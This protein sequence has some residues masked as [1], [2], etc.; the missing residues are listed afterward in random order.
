MR[1]ALVNPN[2]KFDGSIYFGCREAHLPLEF[3][4][5]RALLEAEGHQVELIDAQLHNLSMDEVV[6][7]VKAFK[8]DFAVVTSA[9]SYLFWRCAPPE[10]T[11]PQQ[12]IE[13]VE[14]YAGKTVLVGPHA[15]TT[16]RT[17]L[18]KTGADLAISGEC[19][20]V[21]P[22]LATT[23]LS[24]IPSVGYLLDGQLQGAT[25]KNSTNMAALPA[26][27]WTAEELSLH[28]HHHHRFDEKPDGWGAEMETSRGCPYS[29]SFC[30]KEN[31]RNRYRKRPLP[32]ILD[33]LDALIAAGAQYVYF[34]DEIFLPNRDLLEA[35][36]Q[37]DIK[38]GVQTRIDL[39]DHD[40]LQLLGEAGCVSIEAGVE[41]IT[42]EGRAE[43]NK[44]CKMTTDDMTNRL[45]HARKFVPFVQGNLIQ[46][47]TD[48]AVAVE[49]WRSYL[50]ANGVWANKPVPLFPYPGSPDYTRR[51]GMPDDTAWER[52]HQHYL[53]LHEEF[54]DVQD[55]KPLPLD[56]LE[57]PHRSK[58]RLRVLM[59]CDAVGGVWT[60][61]MDMCRA[62]AAQGSQI[63]L[64]VMGPAMS[65][66]QRAEATALNGV[67]V[68][69]HHG[70]LEWMPAPWREVDEA[71]KWL[72]ELASAAR[73]DIAHLNSFAF[74]A[75]PWKCPVVLVAHSCL[76][77]WWK[78]VKRSAP[79]TDYKGYH[80]VVTRGLNAASVV[81]A[82]TRAVLQD[83]KQLY[84][85][86]TPC[87]VIWNGSACD[88]AVAGTRENFVFSAGRVW[89]EAK[90][91]A[92][93][94]EVAP[95]LPW[96]IRVAGE[97]GPGG[98]ETYPNLRMLGRL[99]RE[100]LCS[101]YRTASIFASPAFYEP[102]GL[103]I[104][105]AALAGCPLVLGDIDS[106][107]EVWQDNAFYVNPTDPA[108]LRDVL[109]R[110]I[111]DDVLRSEYSRRALR[112]A[113]Q[114]GLQRMVQDYLQLYARLRQQP[115]AEASLV[116]PP[117]PARSR[118]KPVPAPEPAR[119]PAAT[120]SSS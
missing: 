119:R 120:S 52:A 35:V 77:G 48:E 10:L 79:P 18:I 74:A 54:S 76:Y 88:S 107:R 22:L 102:F 85:F 51:W 1:Y 68:H 114:F 45:V 66:A 101:H 82:P 44:N 39:W 43:L 73:P 5:S 117:A 29:C 11:C 91:I 97:P 70:A 55:A 38:F 23:P 3:G 58:K 93:L 83:L 9:P 2:W 36:K 37:R 47:G 109:L 110:L 81:V 64:A 59:T 24:E 103:C 16:P 40:M 31:F 78:S 14:P 57:L 15:S 111:N 92:L 94:N 65:A 106:L 95:D 46:A 41:S 27:R 63:T 98:H 87:Q 19:E 6:R 86:S 84:D 34:I 26:L 8:P 62:L 21:L 12:V 4:Y 28:H 89:D 42:E 61:A 60:Y 33:E 115:A 116:S 112:R 25:T 50:L 108:A 56:K 7:R 17:A 90:N 100:E 104:L 30:A 99:S 113:Q 72:M 80:D 118:R 71:G 96:K 105:E 67:T 13:A 69:E 49:N 20:D 53:R 75:L 32:V